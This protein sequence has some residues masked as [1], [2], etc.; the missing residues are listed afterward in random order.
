M[1]AEGQGEDAHLVDYLCGLATDH[2]VRRAETLV[3]LHQPRKAALEATRIDLAASQ[4]VEV[5][6]IEG[7][8]IRISF[9]NT[10]QQI[11]GQGDVIHSR[12]SQTPDRIGCA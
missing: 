1:Y 10:Q 11:L 9:L 2:V 4:A 3:P 12:A 8:P 7:V 5:V 6:A